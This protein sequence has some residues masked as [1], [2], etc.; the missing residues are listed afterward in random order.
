MNDG[1]CGSVILFFFFI[2]LCG[3]ALYKI[4]RR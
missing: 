1:G 4:R 2:A 3:T